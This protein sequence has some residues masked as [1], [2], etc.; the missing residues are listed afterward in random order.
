MRQ[1][2][3]QVMNQSSCLHE[4][5]SG[6]VTSETSFACFTRYGTGSILICNEMKGLSRMRQPFLQVMNQ[7]SCLHEILSGAVT[8]ETSFAC[9]TRCS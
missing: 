7:S 8:S 4:I 1:P 3:L 6:A 5:L 2:F 9:F